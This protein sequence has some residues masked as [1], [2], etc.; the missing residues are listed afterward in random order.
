MKS[1]RGNSVGEAKQAKVGRSGEED[2]GSRTGE[3]E[4][5]LPF[6]I[7]RRR[8]PTDCEIVEVFE[9]QRW[10]A[11]SGWTSNLLHKD[12]PRWS[13][14]TGHFVYQPVSEYPLPGLNW[15]WVDYWKT[16]GKD[17]RQNDGWEYL[18]DLC[19][20]CIRTVCFNDFVCSDN[21]WKNPTPQPTMASLTR[22]RKWI[23]YMRRK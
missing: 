5:P 12:P 16:C 17:E 9:N 13:D 6:A 7:E 3:V 19:F 11:G 8:E 18:Y 10:W 2:R 1:S 4:F 23:R 20:V 15:E 21:D 22:R 14:D